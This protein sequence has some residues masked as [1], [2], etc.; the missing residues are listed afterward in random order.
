MNKVNRIVPRIDETGVK[1][2][3]I[4]SFSMLIGVRGLFGG[5]GL[6]VWT[7]W[8]SWT[9]Q[10]HIFNTNAPEVSLIRDSSSMLINI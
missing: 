3:P 1:L 6:N 5:T 8:S 4:T 7:P 2:L 9:V 10:L